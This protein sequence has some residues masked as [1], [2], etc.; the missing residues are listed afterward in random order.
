MT[1][2]LEIER[3][4]WRAAKMPGDNSPARTRLE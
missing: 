1:Q 2:L 4:R 3:L